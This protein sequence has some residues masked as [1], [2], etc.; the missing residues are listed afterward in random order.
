M[1]RLLLA[2]AAVV[3]F[4]PRATAQLSPVKATAYHWNDTKASVDGGITVRPIVAGSTLDL[5]SLDIRAITLAPGGTAESDG[6][7]D[8]TELFAMV[9][10][11]SLWFTIGGLMQQLGPGSVAVALPG[12]HAA[13]ANKGTTPATIYLFSYRS[14]APM[15]LARGKAAGGSFMVSYDGL[16]EKP[17]ASGTRR[18]VL[19]RPTAMFKRFEAHYSSVKEGMRNHATHTHRADELMMLTKGQVEVL[20]GDTHPRAGGSDIVFLGSMVP[21]SLGNIGKGPTQYLVIQ[22][23]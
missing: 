21:H 14:K 3:A 12:D 23:E 11:G 22:G 9:K 15:D 18:D 10:E 20:L 6:T 17:T 5:D 13:V 19:N 8:D 16:I 2:L 7:H 1:K 4:A